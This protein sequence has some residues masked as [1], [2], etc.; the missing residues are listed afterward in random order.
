MELEGLNHQYDSGLRSPNRIPALT[1]P[2]VATDEYTGLPH[3]LI[4]IRFHN[5]QS[6]KD[7]PIFTAFTLPLQP[8]P[9]QHPTATHRPVLQHQNHSRH[10]VFPKTANFDYNCYTN[11]P[12]P[13]CRTLRTSSIAPVLVPINQ[14]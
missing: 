13:Y 11:F 1:P 7:Q 5:H 6:N 9:K 10:S 3:A 14:I 12:V 4:L 8:I 2:E